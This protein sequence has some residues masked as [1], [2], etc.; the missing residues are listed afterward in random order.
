MSNSEATAAYTVIITTGRG[1]G[2]DRLSDKRWLQF[3]DW[4]GRALGA[5]DATI[6]QRPYISAY[7]PPKDQIGQWEGKTEGAATFVAFVEG[8]S[9]LSYL[10]RALR[11]CC[12]EFKQEAIGFIAVPGTE[13]LIRLQTGN[14]K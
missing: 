10:R 9:Q 14:G 3:H 7:N 13:N 1:H 5:A 12:I 4:I 2:A 8:A 6:V 11:L